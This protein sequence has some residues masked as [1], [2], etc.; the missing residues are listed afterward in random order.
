MSATVYGKTIQRK[1]EII[2]SVAKLYPSCDLQE[3]LKKAVP[4]D[5]F[6]SG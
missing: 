2:R 1:I 3:V 6:F 5:E 4:I